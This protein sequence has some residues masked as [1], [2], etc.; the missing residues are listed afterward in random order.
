M[1]ANSGLDTELYLFN[2]TGAA[3]YGNDDSGVSLQSTLP[4]NNSLGP[5]TP[6][7]Y[8][9]AIS[10]SGNEPINLANQLLFSTDSP[11]TTIRGP[12]PGVSG[13]ESNFDST[14][15]DPGTGAY[16]IDLTGA[17]TPVPEISSTIM[18]G[19]G[20]L[21]IAILAGTRRRRRLSL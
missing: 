6:G 20:L 2:S 21:I 16:E 19:Q 13:S 12:A 9:L 8:Y 18:V 14:F 1:T 17:L 15:A 7:I 11:S 10:T 3:V 4:A 5:L